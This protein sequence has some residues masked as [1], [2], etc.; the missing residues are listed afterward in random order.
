MKET[1]ALCVYFFNE[2]IKGMKNSIIVLLCL[3]ILGGCNKMDAGDNKKNSTSDNSF[4][5]VSNKNPFYFELSNGDAYIPIGLNIC[6]AWGGMAELEQHFK[7]LNE[8]GG[9]YARVWIGQFMFDYESVYGQVNEEQLAK[10]DKLF[11]LADKYGIKIKLCIE[12]FRRIEPENPTGD[13]NIKKAYHVNNGGLFTSMDDYIT[14]E[15]GKNVFLEK[16]RLYKDRYGDNPQVFAWEIWNEMNAI[17]ITD[18]TDNLI[19]WNKD[20]FAE[21]QTIYPKNLI[22]QSLG[23]MDGDWSFPFY[24]K[25]M[26]I[27]D[28][29]IIQGHRYLDEGAQL[30]ICHGPVDLLAADIVTT[31]RSYGQNKP[32]LLAESGGV[33]PNHTGPHAAYNNDKHGTIFHDVLFAP[34]FSGAAGPGHIWHWDEYVEKNNVWFQIQR[35]ANVVKGIN[36]VEEQFIPIRADQTNLRVY[37]LKGIKTSLVWFRDANNTWENELVK[38]IAPQEISGETFHVKKKLANKEIDQI[39]AYNPWTDQWSDIDTNEVIT[40]PAFKR[41][42]VLVIQNK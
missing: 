40:L 26:K 13:F 32:V 16:V 41:S 14:A 22:T 19:Q 24:E 25:I 33:K 21:M 3:F 10:L 1:G 38:S 2:I 39:K 11:E 18:Q 4:V 34:F 15:R 31:L 8:N 27:A 42:M 6:W 17:S 23:S 35:F 29:D 36:P 7:K 20:V 28:N 30:E 9:N 12:N 37:L 5:R